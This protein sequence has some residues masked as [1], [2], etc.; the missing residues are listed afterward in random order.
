MAA[1]SV[2]DAGARPEAEVQ[3]HYSR[4]DLAER[5]FAILEEDGRDLAALTQADIAPFD[6]MHVRGREATESLRDHAGFTADM[7]ILDVGSG[8]GGPA[9]FLAQSVGCQVTG[10]DLTED[11]CRTAN[12]LAETVGLAGQARFQQASALDL[13][14]DAASF[15][16][17]WSQHVQM[18]IADKAGLYG[19]IARVLK[20]GARFAAYDILAGPAGPPH[21]PCPWAPQPD[22]SFLIAPEAWRTSVE[23]AGFA[24]EHWCDRSPE[25]RAWF[26]EASAKA[27]ADPSIAERRTRVM[28]VEIGQRIKNLRRSLDEDRVV[29]MEAVFRRN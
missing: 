26:V 4:G 13:P 18:N 21:Y 2:S 28:G 9:R 14:F 25:A 15:D 8:M 24:V 17:A 27:K 23:A 3:S 16:G 10:I 1:E 6:E 20:P 11:F 12:T 7:Q 19:E 29:L 22:I 5:I